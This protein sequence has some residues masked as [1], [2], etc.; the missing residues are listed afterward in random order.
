MT[1]IHVDAA[2]QISDAPH[3][4]STGETEFL[5]RLMPSD[6]ETPSDTEDAKKTPANAGEDKADTETKETDE[7]AA[8][9]PAADA[10]TEGTAAE[11]AAALAARKYADEGAYVKVKVGDE[12]HEVPVKDLERLF[13][14]EKALTQK[15][16]E[17]STQRTAADAE[18]QKNVAATGALLDRAKARFEPFSKVDFLLA[19]K[20]L[21]AE[22]YT[23]LRNAA[24]SAYEDVQFLEQN[25]NSHMQAAQTKQNETLATQAKEALKTLSGPAEKGGIEGW[26]EALYNDIRGF[27]V[28]QGLDARIVNQLVDPVAIKMLYNAML[29]TRGQSKVVTTKV[30]KTPTKVV[31]TTTSPDAA[32]V[33]QSSDKVKKALKNLKETGSTDSAADA[34]MAR[35][36][37]NDD[38]GE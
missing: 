4:E 16:M 11:K 15:S 23:N 17:A 22:D 34:F 27:A 14:Q 8:E 29:F 5:K 30:N 24:A 12:V 26:T 1:A 9:E 20:E 18:L 37:D 25:L 21:S 13:G 35:W 32:K 7:A 2:E 28:S 3:T 38:V 10:E 33:T 31:K 19:A 6:A 36:K